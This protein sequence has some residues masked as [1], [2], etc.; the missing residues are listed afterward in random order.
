MGE[1]RTGSKF[2]KVSEVARLAGCSPDTVRA[3]ADAGQLPSQRTPGNQ[4][5]FQRADVERFLE[6]AS[7]PAGPPSTSAASSPLATP[8]TA[9]GASTC[10][11]PRPAGLVWGLEISDAD[12]V[13]AD[14]TAELELLRIQRERESVERAMKQ[15]AEQE[16]ERLQAEA[17]RREAEQ[18]RLAAE[19]RLEGYRRFGRERAAD[20]PVAV[21]AQVTTDLASYVCAYRFPSSL[22]DADAWA[23]V[24]ARV[25]QHRDRF[26]DAQAREAEAERQQGERVAEIELRKQR[27]ARLIALGKNHAFFE[28]CSWAQSD[29]EEAG[30][31]VERELEAEVEWDWEDAEV[32]KFVDE[33]LDEMNEAPE[34]G[35]DADG[36]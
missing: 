32:K 17:R 18:A 12:I 15:E 29:M 36:D 1:A 21:Q 16:A 5:R 7:S 4:R 28:T 34:D 24:L 6:R 11:V 35:D 10:T 9:A 23:Y 27:R 3:W 33:I 20:L 2:L 30:A 31:E 14:A 19:E 25:Q 26:R 22:P 13:L 8:A